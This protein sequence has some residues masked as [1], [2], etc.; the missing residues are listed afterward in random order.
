MS[1]LA[2]LGSDVEMLEF[3]G[4]GCFPIHSEIFWRQNIS[5]NVK[6][7]YMSHTP[8]TESEG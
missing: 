5:L 3:I 4:F 2:P 6:C 7:M 8:C 1:Y